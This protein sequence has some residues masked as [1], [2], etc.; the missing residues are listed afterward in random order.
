MNW[1]DFLTFRRM[2]TPY[3]I[4]V[5]FWIGVAL[6]LLSGCAVLVSGI[7]GAGI[8]GGREGAGAVLAAICVSPLVVV[9][10][11]LA[12]RIYAELLMVAFRISETLTDI[13]ELLERQ[14]QTGG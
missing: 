11:V 8:A 14:R 7:S 9:L 5:L 6:S 2:I 13:R 1:S 3:I 12:S 4:Q 10:G